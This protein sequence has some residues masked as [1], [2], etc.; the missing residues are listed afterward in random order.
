M[1][2]SWLAVQDYAW[3]L[4][5]VYNVLDLIFQRLKISGEGVTQSELVARYETALK[6]EVFLFMKLRVL[7]YAYSLFENPHI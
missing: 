7:V 3:L 6:E 2:I 5:L 4:E 1:N